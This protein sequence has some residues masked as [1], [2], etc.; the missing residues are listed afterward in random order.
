MSVIAENENYPFWVTK[1][2]FGFI[3][4]AMS[5]G[6]MLSSVPSGIIRHRYGTKK[7][8]M[9]FAFPATIGVILITIPQNILMV[10]NWNIRNFNFSSKN[11]FS[12]S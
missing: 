3:V 6:A 11:I 1:S 8:M 10:C 2:Q 9:I 5:V 12:S 7:T 4:A